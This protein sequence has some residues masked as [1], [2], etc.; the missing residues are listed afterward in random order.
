MS[1]LDQ[2]IS[3]LEAEIVALG[4]GTAQQPKDG[5]AEWYRLRAL[6]LGRA[7]LLRVQAL[8]IDSDAGACERLYRSQL[9]SAKLQD[10]PPAPEIVRETLPDGS[11]PTGTVA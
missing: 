1:A 6:A 2:A 11:L 4:Q 8:S 7:Y 5:T 10:I 3:D 9:G